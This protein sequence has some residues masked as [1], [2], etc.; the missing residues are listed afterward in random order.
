M[1]SPSPPVAPTGGLQMNAVR[2]PR[3]S[4]FRGAGTIFRRLTWA[5][6]ALAAVIVATAPRPAAA[7]DPEV[8]TSPATQPEP[9][10][11]RIGEEVPFGAETD[12]PYAKTARSKSLLPRLVWST[13]I[14]HPG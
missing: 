8:A 9:G 4:F 13:T 14:E 5:F 2:L 6:G 7:S 11:Y 12:H 3:E 10:P 1:V